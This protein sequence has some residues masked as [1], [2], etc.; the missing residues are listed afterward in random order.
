MPGLGD[1]KAT[2][3]VIS[4]GPA[5]RHQLKGDHMDAYDREEQDIAD[6]HSRG[7]ITNKE[8]NKE[9]RDLQREWRW[10]AEESAQRAYDDEMSRW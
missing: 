4:S 5:T 6:R 1:G 10:E 9:I 7:E 2:G 3:P 8:Y